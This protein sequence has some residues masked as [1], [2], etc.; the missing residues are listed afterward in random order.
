[1]WNRRT[2]GS[3]R[4]GERTVSS[5][6]WWKAL[7]AASE[8]LPSS[9]ARGSGHLC[10]TLNYLLVVLGAASRT[11]YMCAERTW[12]QC[13]RMLVSDWLVA[14]GHKVLHIDGEGVPKSHKLTKEAQV[15]DGQLVYSSTPLFS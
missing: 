4:G 8:I 14:H 12:F 5:M 2:E 15:V 13:H 3:V 9:G 10:V 7:S 6:P 11:A 1:M